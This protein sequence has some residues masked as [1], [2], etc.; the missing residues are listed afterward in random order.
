ML[1]G[2]PITSLTSF[3]CPLISLLGTLLFILRPLYGRSTGLDR[4]ATGLYLCL[5]RCTRAWTSLVW[6]KAYCS[7]PEFT[8]LRVVPLRWWLAA[9][10]LD[11]PMPIGVYRIVTDGASRIVGDREW[12]VECRRCS[13]TVFTVHRPL[14]P[15]CVSQS[16]P[17]TTWPAGVYACVSV[18]VCVCVCVW[19]RVNGSTAWPVGPGRPLRVLLARRFLPANRCIR[20]HN[21]ATTSC[22][23]IVL[24]FLL[25]LFLV[26]FL[27]CFLLLV[28]LTRSS[29]SFSNFIPFSNWLS[30]FFC[31]KLESTRL[32]KA[33]RNRKEEGPFLHLRWLSRHI[34]GSFN[35][36]RRFTRF[37][38]G[39]TGFYWTLLGF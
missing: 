5:E 4:A 35:R 21:R 27:F 17:A 16:V 8:E 20:R 10:N 1:F 11:R 12:A 6:G 28:V 31:F 19:V 2:R 39:R 34:S 9:G 14:R 33:K 26:F 24:F 18:C 36:H 37:L 38:M 29:P 23:V 3:D 25:L 15:A 7:G 32:L 30:W 13:M 22:R